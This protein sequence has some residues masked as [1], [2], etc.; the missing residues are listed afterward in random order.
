M[1]EGPEAGR[2][3]ALFNGIAD[4]YDRLN[5]LLS[6][7]I[8]R[9]WRRRALKCIVVPGQAQAILDVACGTGDFS[10]AIAKKADKRTVVTGIDLS[11]G[12]LAVMAEKVRKGGL[13]GRIRAELGDCEQLR[14]ADTSFDRVTI[15]FGIFATLTLKLKTAFVPKL[16]GATALWSRSCT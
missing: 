16:F 5:H 13:E 4:D 10:I 2:I 6:L 3:Q 11:E 12:M 15:A 8:D 1:T 9:T 14:F 7:G